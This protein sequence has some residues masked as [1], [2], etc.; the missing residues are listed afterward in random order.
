MW[1]I[2]VKNASKIEMPLLSAS[3]KISQEFAYAYGAVILIA[4]FTSALSSGMR[5]YTKYN[6]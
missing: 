4:M 2:G 3:N 1:S 6:M 5:F